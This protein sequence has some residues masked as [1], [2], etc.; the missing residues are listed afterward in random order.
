[1]ERFLERLRE[2]VEG[3]EEEE[4]EERKRSLVGKRREVVKNLKEETG[5]I[6]GIIREGSLDFERREFRLLIPKGAY[7][8]PSDDCWSDAHGLLI[9]HH[10][11]ERDNL[12]ILSLTKPTFLAFYDA[13]ILPSSSTRQKISIH[14]TSSAEFYPT[15]F[16][17]SLI[18]IAGRAWGSWFIGRAW[19]WWFA[20]RGTPQKAG[21]REGEREEMVLRG[22]PGEVRAWKESLGRESETRACRPMEEYM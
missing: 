10:P 22:G 18:A 9:L 8:L 14:F 5:R 20:M 17:P 12:L 11:G 21:G 2:V 19:D 6:W 16:S 3:M 4:W 1:V 15:S 7:H 13:S